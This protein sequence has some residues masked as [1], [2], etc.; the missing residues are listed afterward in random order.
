VEFA[1]AAP[2]ETA[3]LFVTVQGA[4]LPDEVL[5]RCLAVE[6]PQGSLVLHVADSVDPVRLGD[7]TVLAA[8][9]SHREP[10][11]VRGLEFELTLP[12]RLRVSAIEVFADRQRIETAPKIDG[13]TVRLGPLPDLAAG[14][15]LEIRATGKA[16]RDGDD[17]FRAKIVGGTHGT[18]LEASERVTVNR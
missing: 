4:G 11:P 3:C 17:E 10:Q 16:L 8:W 9:V 2:S 7:E 12:E 13:R 1:C 6:A 18:G 15:R 5:E 14:V